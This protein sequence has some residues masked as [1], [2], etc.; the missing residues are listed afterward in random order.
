[1]SLS[2]IERLPTELIQPIFLASGPNLALPLTSH[3]IAAKLSHKST[4]YAVCT[5]YLKKRLIHNPNVSLNQTRLFAS[6]WMTWEYFKSFLF[7]AFEHIGC[8]CGKT[9]QEGCF[10]AQW[11]PNFEDAT[12]MTFSR[13]HCPAL[14]FVKCRLPVKLLHGPWTQDKIQFLR[15][16][17][18]MT[19][20]TVEWANPEVLNIVRE[21]RR[22]AFLEKNLEAVQLFNHNRRLGRSPDLGSVR[23]AVIEA[24][25]VRSIVYDTMA[26]A[27]LS[28]S[29]GRDWDCAELDEWCEKRIEAGD[30][31][32][33]WLKVKLQELR[34]VDIFKS[35]DGD[36]ERKI[37]GEMNAE[38]GD[39]DDEGDE[40]V[41]NDLNWN[42]VRNFSPVPRHTYNPSMVVPPYWYVRLYLCGS[43]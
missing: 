3:Y 6:K 35:R 1:M 2:Y 4:Y 18:W 9:A 37:Y 25:C 11:P 42:K 16:L 20:M 23:F 33:T 43:E 19:S 17:L 12:A 29:R 36:Y 13:S 21:G 26:S 8:L 14:T 15:F 32:G 40:L 27:R 31:K 10:D 30:P 34:Q 41:I 22:Q 28:G 7:D 39:Y 24:D 38:T 5:Q